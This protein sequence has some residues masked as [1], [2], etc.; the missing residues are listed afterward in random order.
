MA[1]KS[2]SMA[3]VTGG[4]TNFGGM[5][6]EPMVGAHDEPQDRMPQI[7][8]IKAITKQ[9][10]GLRRVN[11]FGNQ[12]N[13]K[14]DKNSLLGEI[15]LPSKK[16]SKKDLTGSLLEPADSGGQNSKKNTT[17]QSSLSKKKLD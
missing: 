15:N 3:D 17:R 6:H 7:K 11:S 2:M 5:N 16:P 13:L 4:H 14:R 12:E 10:Q 9:A 1:K 8:S